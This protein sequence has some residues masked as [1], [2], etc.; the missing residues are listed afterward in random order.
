MFF[1]ETQEHD[2]SCERKQM[3]KDEKSEVKRN[4]ET[5]RVLFFL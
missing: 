2:M 5:R 3:M 1:Q 4:E